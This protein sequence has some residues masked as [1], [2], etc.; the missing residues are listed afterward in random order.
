MKRLALCALLTSLVLLPLT[1]LAEEETSLSYDEVVLI[2]EEMA[3]LIDRAIYLAVAGMS[4]YT[5]YETTLQEY[6]QGIVNVIQGPGSANYDPTSG[7]TVHEGSGIQPLLFTLER[8]AGALFDYLP[9]SAVRSLVYTLETIGR[10]IGL[11]GEVAEGTAARP[12]VTF[13]DPDDMRAIYG[14]LLAARGGPEDIFLIGGAQS[15]V[16]LFPSRT[17]WVKTGESVQ[18]AIDRVPD[19]GTIYLEPGSYRGPLEITK[20]VTIA[21][22]S[23]GASAAFG[24]VM[25]QGHPWNVAVDVESEQPISVVLRNLEIYDGAAGILVG[26]PVSLRLESVV[27]RDNLQGV[28]GLQG[29]AVTAVGTQLLAN[30]TGALTL[31]GNATCA[32]RDCRIAETSG[33]GLVLHGEAQLTVVDCLIVDGEE[34]G[35]S[36]LEGSTLHLEE[37]TIVGNDGYGLTVYS[38]DCIPAGWSSVPDQYFTGAIT[39]WGNTIPGPDEE[40][41]NLEGG[42]CP[43]E[44]EFLLDAAPS[45]VD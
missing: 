9:E 44:Y 14:Y 29:A 28:S 17:L 34:S 10:F 36:L 37:S 43:A 13:G 31:S 39:G 45:E 42:I 6:G 40:N 12:P 41:G 8:E 21:A 26:G 7:F 4:P 3:E 30:H 38:D 22:Y 33:T 16:N 32:L 2:V 35:I 19:G 1:V 23:N 24:A 18:E 15:L 20:S 25:I 5:R 11:A 27:I